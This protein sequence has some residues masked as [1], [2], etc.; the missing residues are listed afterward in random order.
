LS[1]ASKAK[2]L[3][4]MSGG[5]DSSSAAFYLTN[6]GESFDCVFFDY[7]Q[8]SARMQL[9]SSKTICD[10]LGKRLIVFRIKGVSVPFVEKGWLRPHEPIT[11]RNLVILPIAIAFAKEKGYGEVIIASVKEDCEYEKDRIIVISKLK[12]LGSMIGIK[13]S[14]PFA[15]MPKW[16]LLRLGIASG[17]N[18]S[19]T[20][21]CLLGHAYHCGQCS[22]CQRRKEAFKQAGISDP[23]RYY[24]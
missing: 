8:R 24:S 10:K 21:S 22:Q 4:L 13:V 1:G 16:M 18:P 23:T 9:R 3:L 11:H 12:E 20:Y 5:L 2:S 7:G 19:D 6:K 14:T 15:L 17:L